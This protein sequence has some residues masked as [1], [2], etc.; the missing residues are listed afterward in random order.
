[1][2]VSFDSLDARG[3]NHRAMT[4]LVQTPTSIAARLHGVQVSIAA[5]LYDAQGPSRSP[6]SWSAADA[7]ACPMDR[8]GMDR[9]GMDRMGMDRA[10]AAVGTGSVGSRLSHQSHRNYGLFLDLGKTEAGHPGG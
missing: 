2:I 6:G 7:S 4:F 9:M 8:A 3:Y 10:G 5:R 1:M